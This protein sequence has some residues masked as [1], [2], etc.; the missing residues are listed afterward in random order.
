[1]MR[2]GRIDEKRLISEYPRFMSRYRKEW[3]AF[4]A[5]QTLTT[6]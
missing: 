6:D 3:E 4:A 5:R 1:M 2:T